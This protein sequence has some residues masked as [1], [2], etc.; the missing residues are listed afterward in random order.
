MS[1]NRYALPTAKSARLAAARIHGVASH[2]SAASH[3]G[4][5]LKNQPDRA[6]VTVPRGRKVRE[7][8]QSDYAVHWADLGGDAVDGWFTSR[9][10]TVLDCARRLPFDEALAVADSALRHGV[11]SSDLAAAAAELRGPGVAQVRRVIAAAD[12]RAMN[13]FESVLRAIAVEA[14]LDVVP[15]LRVAIADGEVFPDLVDEQSRIV[16][17]AD[18][19]TWHASRKQHDRDCERYNSLVAAWWTVLRFTY[20]H[21]MN[22]PAYVLSTLRAMTEGPQRRH[23]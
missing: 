17:E 13:P 5:E 10:R 21:V 4:W 15:Q 7:E 16:L 18:S 22:D 20:E 11:D 12:G 23:G 19:W 6:E 2:L 3:W 8:L 14:G 1:R 9:I